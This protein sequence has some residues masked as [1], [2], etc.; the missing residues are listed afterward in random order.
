VKP[1]RLHSDLREHFILRRAASSNSRDTELH[2]QA[3]GTLKERPTTFGSSNNSAGATPLEITSCTVLPGAARA[4]SGRP[5]N[6]LAS[7]HPLGCSVQST[8]KRS[9]RACALQRQP[10]D[11]RNIDQLRNLRDRRQP[12]AA[13]RCRA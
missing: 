7:R 9:S 12:A 2:Q 5:R 13:A 10:D 11:V 8:L 3:L 4:A 1:S 6:H